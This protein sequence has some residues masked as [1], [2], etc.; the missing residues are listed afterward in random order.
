MNNKLNNK[1]NI[2]I[3]TDQN[4]LIYID[5][6]SVVT[7][8]GEVKM[9][10]INQEE[11]VMYV[12]LEADLIPRTTLILGGE[13]NSLTSIAKGQFNLLSNGDKKNLD[14]SWTETYVPKSDATKDKY[15]DTTGQSFGIDNIQIK[16]VGTNF[17]PNVTIKF[18][19]ARGKT[20][21]DSPEDSPYKAFFHLPWPV[22]YL[23]VKGFYGKAI[24]Y[25][26]HLIKFN[27]YFN[28]SN[29]NFEIDTAFVG[30]TYAYLN[31]IPLRGI[32]NAPYM[33]AKESDTDM[34]FNPQTQKYTKKIKKS[35]KGYQILSS[36]YDE[37][38]SKGLIDKTFPV[39]TL[40]EVITAAG[41]IDKIIEQSIFDKVVEPKILAAIG[42]YEKDLNNFLNQVISWKTVNLTTEQIVVNG[43]EYNKISPKLKNSK[44][45]IVSTDKKRTDTL[46]YLILQNI[47]KLYSNDAFGTNPLVNKKESGKNVNKS[48]TTI[49]LQDFTNIEKY[50][51]ED[52]T[53]YVN[54]D[55]SNGLIQNIYEVIKKYEEKRKLVESDI[56]EQMNNIVSGKVDKTKGFGFSPTIRNI[57]A[58]ILANADTYIRLMK[59]VHLNAFNISEQRKPILKNID[60]DVPKN[61]KNENIYPWPEIKKQS[62]NGKNAILTY[63]GSMDMVNQL[64][65][66]NPVL[67]PEVEFVENYL[68]VST[69]K[70]DPLA[71]KEVEP[72]QIEYVF[73]G[74][75]YTSVS[76]NINSFNNVLN[77]TPYTT[78]I[79]SE[80]LYE[81]YERAKYTISYSSFSIDENNKNSVNAIKKLADIE[82]VN[83]KRT[84]NNNPDFLKL[85]KKSIDQ[86]LMVRIGGFSNDPVLFNFISTMGTTSL[87]EKYPYYQSQLPSI[88]YIKEIN[89]YDFS[90]KKSTEISSKDTTEYS[91]IDDFLKTYT[92]DEYRLNIYPFNSPKYL[93][94]SNKNKLELSDLKYSNNILNAINNNGII[95]SNIKNEYW[96]KNGYRDNLFLNT[97]KV[98]DDRSVNILNTP[99]FH[100]QLF[101][102]FISD[103]KEGKYAGSAYV[104]LNSLPFVELNDRIYLDNND[105]IGTIVSTL[106][107]E[108]GAT[109]NVPYLLV[110]KWGSIYHRYKRYLIENNDII[111][112][113]TTPIDINLFYDNNFNRT[114]SGGTGYT[115]NVNIT[116]NTDFGIYPFYQDLF[117]QIVNNYLFFDYNMDSTG[118]TSGYTSTLNNNSLICLTGKTSLG[119]YNTYTFFVDNTKFNTDLNKS[120]YTLIPSIGGK[121]MYGD[122]PS[123]TYNNVTKKTETIYLVN[124]GNTHQDSFRIIWD[125]THENNLFS[126]SYTGNTKQFP[127]YDE[128]HTTITG[129]YS[130]DTNYKTVVDLIATFKPDILDYFEQIFLEFSSKYIKTE[131]SYS[132]F[133]VNYTNFQMLLSDLVSV[134]KDEIK[135]IDTFEKVTYIK[136][137]QIKKLEKITKKIINNNNLLSITLLN[138]REINDFV[139]GSFTEQSEIKTDFGKY[140]QSQ[141]TDETKKLIKLYIGDFID[142]GK[143]GGINYYEKFFFD[144]NIALTEENI[145]QFRQLIYLY[146]GLKI[147]QNNIDFKTYIIN[148]INPTTNINYSTVSIDQNDEQITTTGV[149]TKIDKRVKIFL[150]RL[151][152]KIN[153]FEITKEQ[154]QLTI[155]RAYNDDILKL[156]LYNMFKSFNDKWIAGNSIGQRLLMEEFLFLDKSNRDIGDELYIDF[157]KLSNISNNLNANLFS[158]FVVLTEDSNIDIRPLPSYVNFYGTNFSKKQRIKPSKDVART[159]F[160]TFLD[161]DYEESSPKIIL[162][163]IGPTSKHL[164]YDDIDKDAKFGNDSFNI[165]D[166]NNNPIIITPDVFRNID[167][168][169][170][171][172][173]VSFEV[174]FGDQNQNIFKTIELDQSTIKNTSESFYV[175][176]NLGSSAS[177]SQTAMMDVNLFDIYRTASY[178]CT[179]TCLGN[180]MIQPTMFFYLKNVPLFRGSY[181]ITEVTHSIKSGSIETSFKGSRIPIQSLPDPKDSFMASYRSLFDKMIKRA[182]VRNNAEDKNKN[183][184]DKTIIVDGISYTYTKLTGRTDKNEQPIETIAGANEFGINFNGSSNE[185]NIQLIN[186]PTI[187]YGD[188]KTQWL[189]TTVID[190]TNPDNTLTDDTHMSIISNSNMFTVD[191]LWSDVKNTN[192]KYYSARFKQKSDF[193]L[194]KLT[195]TY[196]YNPVEKVG[197]TV[198]TNIIPNQKK[199]DGPINVGPSNTDY[200]I[201]LSPTLMKQLKLKNGDILYFKMNEVVN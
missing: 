24:R 8:S 82:S 184:K 19:D 148:N 197:V 182:I 130:L 133:N 51:T 36:V 9:R 44:D 144:N 175:M 57:T 161:V 17:I 91:F 192:E 34:T 177:G 72:E 96:I 88:N 95:T 151:F 115:W 116:G 106:F 38:K 166:I 84:L 22:F 64:N 155:K 199:Y 189:K 93:S 131:L 86:S 128:Y 23:T 143:T 32:L 167:Y 132:M 183:S 76:L 26:L 119:N 127:K 105:K 52:T 185:Q 71:E 187:S 107:R 171:N 10:S 45:K 129:S 4:N 162:Q 164:N 65:S 74:D 14:T 195:K 159:L 97:L 20:L 81:I 125:E 104:F 122:E 68:Q 54:T 170:S 201:A 100:K 75:D 21:F 156:E 108:I 112:G 134:D 87:Y 180:A 111:S 172:R 30:S 63:P 1:D 3:K 120:S 118:S 141:L 53:Y 190:M 60:S 47:K 79:F 169:K 157:T 48:L 200:G 42:E 158:T 179:V 114:Y 145:K 139:I 59:D 109:V 94:Y 99:Y 7:N 186:N 146:S 163:Y 33:F 102:D 150:D 35:S 40:R 27:T 194:D 37:Y 174:S 110:A 2:L 83:L 92:P 89:E 142:T 126:T 153:E 56:E 28:S 61:K 138:P 18:I 121:I 173:A 66:N 5:P 77:H 58:V 49:S 41:R 15:S 160:G 13:R 78:S 136:N 85:L 152:V 191:V 80:L 181:W 123:P 73:D 165:A 198:T 117:N 178:Q 103:K 50:I 137:S 6:N 101:D 154:R 16:I 135:G 124:T 193:I 55:G 147:N 46:E 90:I 39:K 149:L 168:N 62:G 43:Q 196:F 188:G 69:Y 11:M 31:D 98:D 29:G 113:I 176:E 12:N 140:N 25:R 70:S 67:W